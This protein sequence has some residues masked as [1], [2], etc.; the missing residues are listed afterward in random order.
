MAVV[1]LTDSGCD[2]T[3]EEANRI[4][5]EI[6]PVYLVFGNAKLRDGIDIDRATFYRRL[7]AGETAKTEPPSADD[8]TSAFLKNVGAGNDVVCITLSSQFSQS[9][10]NATAAA[11]AFPDRVH[12]V[13]SRSAC[14]MQVLLARYAAD[15]AKTGVSAAEIAKTVGPRN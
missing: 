10:A 14:G 15:L 3:R 11:A 2:L 12:L 9:Y 5:I 1:V 7:K 4:G 6:V 8:F 13:D